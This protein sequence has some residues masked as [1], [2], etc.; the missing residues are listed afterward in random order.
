MLGDGKNSFR[1][2]ASDAEGR[3][4]RDK[5]YSHSLLYQD[6]RFARERSERLLDTFSTRAGV[7]LILEKPMTGFERRKEG[8]SQHF[9]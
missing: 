5:F 4:R 8:D 1:L 2:C 3:L 7:V 6:C 9:Y